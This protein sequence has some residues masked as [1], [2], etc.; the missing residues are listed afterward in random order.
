MKNFGTVIFVESGL[1]IKLQTQNSSSSFKT[2]GQGF[3]TCFLSKPLRNKETQTGTFYVK[4][5]IEQIA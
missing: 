1:L 3:Q 2:L 4:Q 5:H